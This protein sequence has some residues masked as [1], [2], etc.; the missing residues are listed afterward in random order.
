LQKKQRSTNAE[1]TNNK[2][3]FAIYLREVACPQEQT[4]HG[5][6]AYLAGRRG[7]AKE[8][9]DFLVHR[10]AGLRL[11]MGLTIS[12]GTVGG[13]DGSVNVLERI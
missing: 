5:K 10:F 11:V 1:T 6:K 7:F 9:F 8:A 2:H 12:I 4:R 3:P 13:I